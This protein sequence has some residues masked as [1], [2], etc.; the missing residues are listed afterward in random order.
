MP[1]PL[2]EATASLGLPVLIMVWVSVS[3]KP[4]GA[5]AEDAGVHGLSPRWWFQAVAQ[6]QNQ[7][8]ETPGSERVTPE[9]AR[10]SPDIRIQRDGPKTRLFFMPRPARINSSTANP[11][12]ASRRKRSGGESAVY[13]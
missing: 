8:V 6:L 1:H 10:R 9:G 4:S 7:I 2:P 5:D 3:R 12:R 11:T 13:S